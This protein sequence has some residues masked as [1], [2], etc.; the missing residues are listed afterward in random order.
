MWR[1]GFV[2]DTCCSLLVR[3]DN[4]KLPAL[5]SS[6]LSSA[7]DIGSHIHPYAEPLLALIYTYVHMHFTAAVQQCSRGKKAPHCRLRKSGQT[8]LCTSVAKCGN[9][10][11]FGQ[12]VHVLVTVTDLVLDLRLLQFLLF[13]SKHLI[14][15]RASVLRCR[16]FW[17]CDLFFACCFHSLSLSCCNFLPQPTTTCL[18]IFLSFLFRIPYHFFLR[19]GIIF[20]VGRFEFV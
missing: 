7:T 13:F 4:D 17:L 20:V 9:W 11:F 12:L 10:S 18:F 6:L 2:V 19:F 8:Y 1:G 15:Q 3:C 14:S 5:P 16:L